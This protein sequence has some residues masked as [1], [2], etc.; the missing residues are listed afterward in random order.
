MLGGCLGSFITLVTYRL[1][2]NEDI[3]FKPSQC[4]KCHKSLGILQLFPIISFL[5]QKGKCHN[6]KTKISIRY[7]ITEVICGIIAAIL[8]Y[9]YHSNFSLNYIIELA[10][11]LSL[12]AMIITDLENLIVPDEIMIFLFIICSIYNYLN[13]SDFIF[14]YSSS[15]ILASLLFFTGIIVSK[16]KKRDSLGFADV[17]FVASIGCL[18]P[19]HSLPAYLFISGIVG[20]VTSLISQKLT[21]KEE[22]PFIPALAFSFII[23]FNNINILTF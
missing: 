4:P 15:V 7:P 23:C 1:P 2:R 21:D 19:L 8:F 14:N 3:V 6:C 17:K 9:K 16:I 22:F 12:F 10:I 11:Y 13:F 5:W 18:L 20:V